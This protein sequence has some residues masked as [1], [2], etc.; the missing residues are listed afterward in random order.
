MTSLEQRATPAFIGVALNDESLVGRS[1]QRS[2]LQAVA[3]CGLA[4]V[5]GS[6]SETGS[7]IG[8]ILISQPLD[9]TLKPH[10]GT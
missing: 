8:S 9:L 1:S 2:G 6:K 4:Q 5:T 10:N 7:L 3:E